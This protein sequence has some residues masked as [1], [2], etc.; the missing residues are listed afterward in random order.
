MRTNG[1]MKTPIWL[2][3]LLP[4]VAGC[5]G[6][7]QNSGTAV[8]DGQATAAYASA[9]P[10][11][12]AVVNM[13]ESVSV[14][15]SSGSTAYK[16]GPLDVLEVTVF[17]VPDLSKTAQVSEAGTIN[18]PLIGEVAVAGK[19][20]RDVEQA[21]TKTL[22]SKFLKNPQVSVY[23][24]EYN[25]QRVT[26]QGSVAKPGIYPIQG[27]LTLLQ[28]MALS[29]GLDSVSDDNV[30]IFRNVDGK[31]SVARYNV[32]QVQGGEAQDPPLQ[33]GDIIVA[34]KSSFKEG[35]NNLMKA[36]PLASM[37]LLL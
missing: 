16:I 10:E 20:S 26:V 21:I 35:F 4:L 27:K 17:K 23:V 18:Y 11:R 2:L 37:F 28:V 8:T 32:N 31:R 9:T 19:S 6:S 24:K 25:S 13:A 14:G 33:A 15:S 5:V 29:G 3:V 7:S 1:T 30:V 22:G 12:A 34:G 36:L